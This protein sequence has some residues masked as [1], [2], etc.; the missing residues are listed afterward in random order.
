MNFKNII[1][2][3]KDRGKCLYNA[4]FHLYET[5]RTGRAIETKSRSVDTWGEGW[6]GGLTTN[7][8]NKLCG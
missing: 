6:E 7:G 5:S 3:E 2:S 1:L 8:Q 4:W